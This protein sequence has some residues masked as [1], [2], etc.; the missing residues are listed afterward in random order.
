M[1]EKNRDVELDSAFEAQF[2]KYREELEAQEREEKEK[3]EMSEK[4]LHIS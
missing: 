4:L 1:I 3:E 2:G